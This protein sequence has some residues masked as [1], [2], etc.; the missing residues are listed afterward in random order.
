MWESWEE[1]SI[2]F[3]PRSGQTHVLTAVA[4]EALL[5]LHATPRTEA[6]LTQHLAN[7]FNLETDDTLRQHVEDMLNHFY[8]LGLVEITH[9]ADQQHSRRPICRESAL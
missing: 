9:N 1:E 4:A 6:E 5:H 7:E 2:V 8:E 3:D